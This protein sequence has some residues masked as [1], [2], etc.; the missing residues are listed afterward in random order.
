MT[1]ASGT[2]RVEFFVVEARVVGGV[3]REDL[4]KAVGHDL[5]HA[6]VRGIMSSHVA[7]APESATVE[8]QAS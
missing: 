1:S 2:A 8:L 6:P 5:A 4:D 7:S 3:S